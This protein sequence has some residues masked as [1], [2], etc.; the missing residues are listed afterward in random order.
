MNMLISG[1]LCACASWCARQQ[2]S[3]EELADCN[4][5]R[6][7]GVP[8]SRPGVGFGPKRPS[9]DDALAA[10]PPALHVEADLEYEGGS[11]RKHGAYEQQNEVPLTT[12]AR[13]CHCDES[14]TVELADQSGKGTLPDGCARAVPEDEVRAPFA[15]GPA[16]RRRMRA[17]EGREVGRDGVGLGLVPKDFM[18]SSVD[19]G[20]PVENGER[21][22]VRHEDGL[23]LVA[24]PSGRFGNLVANVSRSCAA[25]PSPSCAAM[26]VDPP[27][28]GGS[29]T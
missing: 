24:H 20:D 23:I 3:L 26:I 21:S 27:T 22:D 11:K 19:H 16:R 2:P 28:R 14:A 1:V 15:Q 8:D 9:G 4:F 29:L 18:S 10:E 17:G 13:L 5:T 6:N 25:R 12:G 7:E